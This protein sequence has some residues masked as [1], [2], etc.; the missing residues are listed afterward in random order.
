MSTL[1]LREN[2]DCKIKCARKCIS[3]STSDQAKTMLSTA[4]QSSWNCLSDVMFSVA[5]IRFDRYAFLIQLTESAHAQDDHIVH[6]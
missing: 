5:S 2:E 1:D 3:K 4:T 6:H